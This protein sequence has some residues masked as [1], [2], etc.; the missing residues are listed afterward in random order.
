MYCV[1]CE[2]LIKLPKNP[3]INIRSHIKYIVVIVTSNHIFITL[4][5]SVVWF[6]LSSLLFSFWYGLRFY[7]VFVLFCFCHCFLY[8]YRAYVV[9]YYILFTE[10]LIQ[11]HT[12]LLQFC[13]SLICVDVDI[14]G[15]NFFNWVFYENIFSIR[16]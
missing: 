6:F 12:T 7:G 16:F 1:Q 8:I 5:L 10:N 14:F 13:L 9:D 4:F 11:L 3:S 2:C 15:I